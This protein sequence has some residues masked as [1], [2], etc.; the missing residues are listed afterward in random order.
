MTTR[1]SLRRSAAWLMNDR[2]RASRSER[3]LAIAYHGVGAVGERHPLDVTLDVEQ[4]EEQLR[5]LQHH[6][7][8]VPSSELLDAVKVRRW[9]KKLP[10]AIT[11]DDDLRSHLTFTK[12]VLDRLGIP[13]TF[14]IGG[15]SLHG[16]L[17]FWWERLELAYVA[18]SIDEEELRKLVPRREGSDGSDTRDMRALVVDIEFMAPHARDA[19]DE[20]LGSRAGPG[21]D[22]AGLRPDDVRDLSD[23]GRYEIGFH[24]RSHYNLTVLED[25]QLAEE[26]TAGRS[27]LARI[28]GRELTSIA[29]PGGR[30]NHRVVD[31][32]REAGFELGFTCDPIPADPYADPLHIGRLVPN[33]C[34]TLGQFANAV[35]SAMAGRQEAWPVIDPRPGTTL[36]AAA[37]ATAQ[38]G[39]S[40]DRAHR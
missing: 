29:Y 12:P 40:G 38:A 5:Y 39:G 22:D 6:Y 1:E 2:S 8:L 24:T 7:D 3:G 4:F 23:G 13:A 9:G 14:F 11:F 28:I 32:A 18:G 20:L 15:A 34:R 26:L 37:P 33:W 30:W 16:P 19:L 17:T 10:L 31:A 25:A 35:S 21:P 36:A 27:E